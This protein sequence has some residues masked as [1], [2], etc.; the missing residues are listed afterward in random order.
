[1]NYKRRAEDNPSQ[2]QIDN[3]IWVARPE[4]CDAAIEA[5]DRHEDTKKERKRLK[6]R[7]IKV[8]NFRVPCDR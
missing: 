4:T 1:M 3:K 5:I 7:T 6:E 2:E 8:K